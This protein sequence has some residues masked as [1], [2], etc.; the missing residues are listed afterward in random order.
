MGDYSPPD[1]AE[2][3]LVWLGFSINDQWGPRRKFGSLFFK[4]DFWLV[5]G[6]ASSEEGGYM[7]DVWRATP[8][9]QLSTWR[10]VCSE[11]QWE[12]RAGFGL[13]GWEQREAV[14]L[15]GG[16]SVLP[17]E[18]GINRYTV[19]ND[20]WRTDGNAD[21]CS[22]EQ[23]PD[24]Q[25]GA[26]HS[27]ATAMYQGEDDVQPALYLAGG[28]NHEGCLD[29]VW[30][31]SHDSVE[32]QRVSKGVEAKQRHDPDETT[33]WSPRGAFKMLV[34]GG[35][36]MVFGGIQYP[37]DVYCQEGAPT[38]DQELCLQPVEAYNDV[39]RS[40]DGHVWEEITNSALWSPRRGFSAVVYSPLVGDESLWIFG[41]V[42]S[43][44]VSGDPNSGEK[45]QNGNEGRF[46][47]D[48]YCSRDG[49]N[50]KEVCSSSDPFKARNR[51]HFAT[52]AVDVSGTQDEYF[53]LYGGYIDQAP[54][55]Q[56]GYPTDSCLDGPS[57]SSPSST[58]DLNGITIMVFSVGTLLVLSIVGFIVHRHRRRLLKK[59][60]REKKYS[61]RHPVA[62]EES[63]ASSIHVP[64]IEEQSRPRGH[65]TSIPI[66]EGNNDHEYR[67]GRLSVH[68][69]DKSM[70]GKDRPRN[71][72][73]SI[74]SSQCTNTSSS[75]PQS[76]IGRFSGFVRQSSTPSGGMSHGSAKDRSSFGS[77][78]GIFNRP[79]QSHS[80]G[81]GSN[82]DGNMSFESGQR[83]LSRPRA[84]S[85]RKGIF[86]TFFQDGMDFGMR[87]SMDSS[88]S[89][90]RESITT[91]EEIRE[92]EDDHLI[93]PLDLKVGV[94]IGR[95][96]QGHV[97][98]GTYMGMTVAVKHF[99]NST[100]SEASRLQVEKEAYILSKIHHPYVVR[101]FGVCVDTECTLK[102]GV[103]L[104]MEL[105]V[106]SLADI[107]RIK[108]IPRTGALHIRA[109]SMVPVS[110]SAPEACTR[111]GNG[112]AT[113]ESDVEATQGV[114]V[115]PNMTAA[116][117]LNAIK[118]P[119][120]SINNNDPSSCSTTEANYDDHTSMDL[121]D[122]QR[123]LT[124]Q[125]GQLPPSRDSKVVEDTF[126]MPDVTLKS[127]KQTRRFQN[128]GRAVSKPQS[129]PR[130]NELDDCESLLN[131]ESGTG[132]ARRNS[133]MNSVNL[134]AKHFSLS[135]VNSQ[136]AK[137]RVN[138]PLTWEQQ[139]SILIQVAEG[140]SFIHS[141]RFIHRDLKPGNIL[142]D[143]L[144]CAKIC[145][146]GAA[147]WIG[148]VFEYGANGAFTDGLGTTIYMAPEVL[149][150][151]N[152][153]TETVDVYSFGMV[154]F[155]VF[156]CCEPFGPET[157]DSIHSHLELLNQ[158]AKGLR[159]PAQIILSEHPR[160][161]KLMQKC[162]AHE[163]QARPSFAEILEELNEIRNL[164]Q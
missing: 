20:V 137:I 41:G 96:G 10:E 18:N 34:F 160:F 21:A 114:A 154:M 50:W 79:S 111:E 115:T 109:K 33:H 128:R 68:T 94:M 47:S 80:T 100:S 45:A 123:E 65:S 138:H 140:M 148:E 71:S 42:E 150:S 12:P 90:Q 103:S 75:G 112:P 13:V 83:A 55:V 74:R 69:P 130:S 141:K 143:K 95:G 108:K 157:M 73:G 116:K 60:R 4:G 66:P 77:A 97:Y 104:V 84:P 122:F 101:L 85:M 133:S 8:P 145:D 139:V 98:R 102:G 125:L 142:I 76:I 32:W 44:P 89:S 129:L 134:D 31:L 38:N 39:W 81:S 29:D 25:W 23:L 67:D 9:D 17:D 152:S 91:D 156:T 40:S 49:V 117:N 30:K 88:F 59:S 62:G 70:H 56:V 159:P 113:L 51:S 15:F 64:L 36:L 26:R 58:L 53:Y 158:I 161:G 163:P 144:W 124:D 52:L 151:T 118:T 135:Y 43:D 22:W 132:K 149:K 121:A 131:V 78:F 127:N 16:Y 155:A 126:D 3:G 107:V 1:Q 164:P 28:C 110:G 106:F 48:V 19:Y 153:Y 105:G 87:D 46:L 6:Q 24:A 54:D 162:W 37:V 11:C 99:P 146:F 2:T 72:R 35:D 5:G 120:N 57:N 7:G 82:S 93:K 136:M 147:S 63:Q 92:W 61:Y 27:F 86:G 14:F 119:H